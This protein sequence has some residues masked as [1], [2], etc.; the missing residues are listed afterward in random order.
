MNFRR[1]SRVKSTVNG[2]NHLDS[3]GAEQQVMMSSMEFCETVGIVGYCNSRA[4]PALASAQRLSAL[5]K[6]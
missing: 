4:A 1:G 5:E 2:R 3:S 6:L